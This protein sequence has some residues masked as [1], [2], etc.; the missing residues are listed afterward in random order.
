MEE[1]TNNLFKLLCGGYH[2]TREKTKEAYKLLDDSLYTKR[3]KINECS[4]SDL[5]SAFKN[6]SDL[7]YSEATMK[8]ETAKEETRD[9]IFEI[10]KKLNLLSLEQQE[11][12][13]NRIY[14]I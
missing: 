12:I 4:Y 9:T 6:M 3:F 11:I 2:W 7:L 13:A 8:E 10:V 1:S 14:E 5:S